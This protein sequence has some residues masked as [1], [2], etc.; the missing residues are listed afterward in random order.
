[1]APDTGAIPTQRFGILGSG[2]PKYGCH[3]Q[4][5]RLESQL[6]DLFGRNNLSCEIWARSRLTFRVAVWM[7]RRN[8]GSLVGGRCAFA[9]SSFGRVLRLRW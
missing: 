3:R 2:E 6:P 4:A 1:V 9:C 5:L 8:H 7:M